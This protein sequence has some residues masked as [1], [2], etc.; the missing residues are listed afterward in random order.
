M[1][2]TSTGANELC[3]S[4]ACLS[5]FTVWVVMTSATVTSGAHTH[6][7]THTRT[8][9]V[10]T[11]APPWQPMYFPVPA[12]PFSLRPIISLPKLVTVGVRPIEK[13]RHRLK[14]NL[15]ILARRKRWPRPLSKVHTAGFLLAPSPGFPTALCFIGTHP[16]RCGEGRCFYPCWHKSEFFLSSF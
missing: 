15:L 14:F 9:S 5:S 8:Q 1:C 4:S 16:L 10:G 3:W 7:H 2:V 12:N 6:T 13:R 11:V